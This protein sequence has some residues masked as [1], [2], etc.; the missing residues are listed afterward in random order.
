MNV[1][2]KQTANQL[3]PK[4]MALQV[5]VTNELQVEDAV[6]KTVKEFG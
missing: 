2:G 1:V 5:D 3:K 6:V 4:G